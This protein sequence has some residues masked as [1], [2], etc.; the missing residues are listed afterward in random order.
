[1]D[2]Q[3]PPRNHPE[4]VLE[5]QPDNSASFPSHLRYSYTYNRKYIIFIISLIDNNY[6]NNI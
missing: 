1:M 5:D 4:S 2:N 6:F 3:L